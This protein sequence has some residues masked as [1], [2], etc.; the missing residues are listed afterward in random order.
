MIVLNVMR[1]L[2]HSR[3]WATRFILFF[4]SECASLMSKYKDACPYLSKFK[5]AGLNQAKLPLQ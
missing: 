3:R 1:C 4:H 2:R 5:Y